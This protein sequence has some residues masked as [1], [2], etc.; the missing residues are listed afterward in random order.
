[1]AVILRRRLPRP[2]MAHKK[3]EKLAPAMTVPLVRGAEI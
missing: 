3:D 2:A 1:M